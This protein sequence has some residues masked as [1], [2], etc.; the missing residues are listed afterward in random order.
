[1]VEGNSGEEHRAGFGGARRKKRKTGEDTG[2]G[3]GFIGAHCFVDERGRRSGHGI[4]LK[5][6]GGAGGS[7]GCVAAARLRQPD[8]ARRGEDSGGSTGGGRR[9][10]ATRGRAA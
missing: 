5:M 10:G 6:A 2:F 7:L 1:V 8:V 9:N 4:G 3:S